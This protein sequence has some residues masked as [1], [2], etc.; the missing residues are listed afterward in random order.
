MWS[1]DNLLSECVWAEFDMHCSYC[2]PKR[3]DLI[4]IVA[5]YIRQVSLTVK[6]FG[7]SFQPYDALFSYKDSRKTISYIPHSCNCLAMSF[8]RITLPSTYSRIIADEIAEMGGK[9]G[10]EL[11]E[12]EMR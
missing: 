5:A 11:A 6:L 9:R 4:Q 1:S 10:Q 7:R 8:E 3:K 12:S 2:F